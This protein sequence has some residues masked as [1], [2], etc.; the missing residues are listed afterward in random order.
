M[1]K[2]KQ[3]EEVL[4]AD[5]E[6]TEEIIEQV[7]EAVAPKDAYKVPELKKKD[8]VNP[9]PGHATRAFRN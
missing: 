4:Q 1:A 9:Y 5:V 8:A 7:E 6:L 2:N 3:H